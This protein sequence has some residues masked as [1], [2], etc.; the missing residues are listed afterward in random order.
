MPASALARIPA[1][2]S[3]AEAAP[4]GCAG[5]TFMVRGANLQAIRSNGMRLISADWLEQVARNEKAS[6]DYAA[7]GAQHLVVGER[8]PA[9]RESRLRRRR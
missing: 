8:G 9:R 4:L 7:T 3:D 5:V 2:L 1:E 6:S